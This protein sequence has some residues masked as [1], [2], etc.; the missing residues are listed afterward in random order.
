MSACRNA[1]FLSQSG[2][3]RR[4]EVAE[5]E[6]LGGTM[7][8]TTPEAA[9]NIP[10][11]FELGHTKWGRTMTLEAKTVLLAYLINDPP[12]KFKAYYKETIV[13]WLN[14]NYTKWQ[15]KNSDYK[16]GA[17]Y[18]IAI[19]LL[20]NILLVLVTTD[21]NQPWEDIDKLREHVKELNAERLEWF[22]PKEAKN[23][24]KPSENP[25]Q[26]TAAEIPPAAPQKDQQ[27]AA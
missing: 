4:L 1:D 27:H 22:P 24:S 23:Q 19:Y 8:N 16:P 2:L 17:E 7:T 12:E 9:P 3:S 13:P 20:G 6:N 18:P 10:A 25:P 5:I 26:E 14:N 11:K 15:E 21:N